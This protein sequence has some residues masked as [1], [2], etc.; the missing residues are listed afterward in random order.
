[1]SRNATR[2]ATSPASPTSPEKATMTAFR[3]SAKILVTAA[4][5]LAAGAAPLLVPGQ[6]AAD[7]PLVVDG[8]DRTVASGWGTASTGG[9]W[10][11]PAYTTMS[12]ANSEAKVSGVVAGRTFRA[13]QAAVSAEDAE[14]RVDFTLPVAKDFQYTI[15]SRKQADG[16]S[17][18]ARIRIDSTGKLSLELLRN[19]AGT[20]SLLKGSYMDAVPVAVGQKLTM[21]ISTK[22][23]SPVVVQGKVYATGAAEPSWQTTALDSAANAVKVPGYTGLTFYNGPSNPTVEVTT[24]NFT[25]TDV[26]AAATDPGT[27]TGDGG[28]TT[29]LNVPHGA[30]AV[31]SATYPAPAN[32]L[33]VSPTGSDTGTGTITSPF[34]T[35]TKALAKNTN[36]QTIVL[37][38]GTYHEQV[39]VPPNHAAT[40]QPYPNEAV[41]FD[42]TK[43]LDGFTASSGAWSANYDLKL[44]SGPTY[45]QGAPDGTAAG[46]QFINPAY[47]MA[48]HPDMIFLNNTEQKE[49]ASR[50][51]VVPGTFY[52]DDANSKLYLGSDPTGKTVRASDLQWAF[53]LRAPGTVLRGFGVRRFAD[54]VYQQ[55]AITSYYEN[56][57][58]DNMTILD[59]AT[60]GLGFFKPNTTIKNTT[61]DGSGQIGI[62]ASKAD[63]LTINNV[64][65]TDSNDEHFN[66]GPSAG[67][68]KITT[69]RNV[70]FSNS[71]I[72]R[73]VGNQ[74]WADESAYNITVANNEIMDGDRY[75]I[76]VEISSTAS[77]V[78]NIVANNA[79][80]G[81]MI[82]DTD[83]VNIWNNTI[84]N[85]RR[86]VAMAQDSRRIQQLSVAG[87]DP[88]RTQPDLT[89]PW[90]IGNS[91]IVNNIMAAGPD[92]TAVLAVE[93]YELAFNA[94]DLNIA[95][96]G[97]VYSQPALGIPNSAAVWARKSAQPYAFVLLDD[98]RGATGQESTSINPL[99][100]SPVDSTYAPKSSIAAKAATVAMA[101][102]ADIAA[103]A[104]QPT[105]VKNLGAWARAA[106]S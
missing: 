61:V 74:F 27:G 17:Y 26:T 8:F 2:T 71:E 48:S 64:S 85:N 88:R 95:S 41:W 33:Y 43:V 82:A 40:I 106:Q 11:V 30:G 90:V 94:N 15:E 10:T 63:N 101:A 93:S 44:D 69:T 73:S 24:Q 83:K 105:G 103:K 60:A 76:F 50:S 52:V 62:Q 35:L 104:G 72:R 36:G 54:S 5:A 102:P 80:D 6:A 13:Y 99:M 16:S 14:V 100:T 77:I 57:T 22:G 81:I 89:M 98:F 21:K 31:G 51:L 39:V 9:A 87:H 1:M 28:S 32:A 55:G 70:V 59:S 97:N 19:S 68:V 18:V 66:P 42:G 75:G 45:T 65:V 46:W 37:R 47:P 49:V 96:N 53:S 84:V 86:A 38:A 91:T 4:L 12:V 34:K 3:R 25:T 56:Q 58:L 20:L 92:A 67:G 78:N 7:T 23:D 79:Y 29:E